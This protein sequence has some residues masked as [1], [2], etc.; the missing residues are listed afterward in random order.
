MLRRFEKL[1]SVLVV[2]LLCAV[3]LTTFAGGGGG[4][5][6]GKKP[7]HQQPHKV[8]KS[9]PKSASTISAPT[10]FTQ[11]SGADRAKVQAHNT[12]K[13]NRVQA[14]KSL[15]DSDDETDTL[16]TQLRSDPSNNAS[17]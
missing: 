11:E 10:Q 5:G 12:A 7:P 9:V 17:A 3:P 4:V 13:T 14:Q 15:K 6:G 1:L 16:A 2:V 8:P